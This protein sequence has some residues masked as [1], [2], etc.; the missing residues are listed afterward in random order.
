MSVRPLSVS[1]ED[2]ITQEVIEELSKLDPVKQTSLKQSVLIA[3]KKL[4]KATTSDVGIND[5]KIWQVE[6]ERMTAAE[7]ETIG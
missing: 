7:I 2:S 5:A 1:E 3:I 6:L 4:E